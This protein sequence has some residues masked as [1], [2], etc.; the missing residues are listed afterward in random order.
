M[1]ASAK[2]KLNLSLRLPVVSVFNSSNELTAPWSRFFDK[3][4]LV[5]A[6]REIARL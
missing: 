2:G 5:S 1:R 6:G 3:M 4:I